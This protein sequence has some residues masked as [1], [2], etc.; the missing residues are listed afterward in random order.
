M[1]LLPEKGAESLYD[2]PGSYLDYSDRTDR[3]K[4]WTKGSGSI[5]ELQVRDNAYTEMTE[6]PSLLND[7]EL[8]GTVGPKTLGRNALSMSKDSRSS[9]DSS[10]HRAVIVVVVVALLL[11]LLAAIL[12]GV[13]LTKNTNETTKTVVA[14]TKQT[15]LDTG[16][17][18]KRGFFYKGDKAGKNEDE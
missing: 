16:T 8:C 5:F 7:K 15:L 14:P 12:A 1:A 17:R 3:S 2:S 4:M 18:G 6:S 11:S 10:L 13:A 9:K